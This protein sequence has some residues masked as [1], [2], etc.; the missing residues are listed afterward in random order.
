MGVRK[1]DIPMEA[2]AGKVLR[3]CWISFTDAN[4]WQKTQES[5]SAGCKPAE[6]EGG[7]NNL[8]KTH[9]PYLYITGI[10]LSQQ[11]K[12]AIQHNT[13][14]TNLRSGSKGRNAE[15]SLKENETEAKPHTPM[16]M[17]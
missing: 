7:N 8:T 1:T 6:R 5:F 10:Y 12:K 9:V 4:P 16:R 3:K 15:E 17:P 2:Q 11:S 14:L 13:R